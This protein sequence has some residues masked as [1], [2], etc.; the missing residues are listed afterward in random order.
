M[1]TPATNRWRYKKSVTVHH[2]VAGSD[3]AGIEALVVAIIQQ[4]ILDYQYA[5]EYLKGKKQV[6]PQTY[7]NRLE[8]SAE[9]TKK[10]IVRFFKSQ[11]YGTLC[12]IDYHIILRK[13][14]A[15]R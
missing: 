11:W 5:D 9:A 12:D 1:T 3:K 13:L 7:S 8:K 14:G 4:A 6:C 10:E 2:N 15:E